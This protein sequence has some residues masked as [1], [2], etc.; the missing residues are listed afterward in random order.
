MSLADVGQ[1][2]V[3]Y[4]VRL[5]DVGDVL[6]AKDVFEALT[7]LGEDLLAS[8]LVEE[9]W[10]QLLIKTQL[11]HRILYKLQEIVH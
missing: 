5:W 7:V 11:G 10:W 6:E 4:L 1:H 8:W 3:E 9:L 2:L